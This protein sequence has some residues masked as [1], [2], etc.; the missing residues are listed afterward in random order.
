[1]AATR[2]SFLAGASGLLGAAVLGT[3][4]CGRGGY[5]TPEGTLS[6]W[7]WDGSISDTVLAKAPKVTGIPL[8][9]QKVPFDYKSKLLT[10]LAGNAYIP[11]MCG[12]NE[13]VAT[14]F[15]DADQFWD[16]YELGA[17]EVEDQYLDWKWQRGVT[18]DGRLLGFPMD[19][20]PTAL[21][22]RADLLEKAGLPSE[23]DELAAAAATWEQYLDLAEEYKNASDGGY[24]ID[25][26]STI[27]DQVVAQQGTRYMTEQDEFIGDGPQ[28]RRAWDLAVQAHQRELTANAIETEWNAAVSTGRVASF[29]GAVWMSLGLQDAA[30]STEGKWRVCR[31]PGGPGNSGGSFVGIPKASRD[32]KG[33]WETIK[34]V[35]SPENQ[36]FAYNEI[37]LFPAAE[38]GLT[39]PEV[40]V[41][42]PFYGGQIVNKTFGESAAN[43]KPVY[44]SAYDGLI[45]PAFTDQVLNIWSANAD[46]EK[47]WQAALDEVERQLAHRGVI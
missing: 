43:V 6:L 30:A 47:A 22:F 41:E 45:G 40:L 38:A 32:P 4:G 2:R 13:D 37:S 34:W 28:I 17:G 20:G 25:S 26:V 3:A 44:L 35:Q 33:A 15:P 14:Y 36:I 8:S 29:V 18:P 31:A 24:L 16:L 39:D 9:P 46:P 1:M 19:T 12:F 21:Y 23:P 11:D 10:S 7:Y 5:L 42:H 27:Y